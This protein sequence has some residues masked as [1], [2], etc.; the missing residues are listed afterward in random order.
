MIGEYEMIRKVMRMEHP[1][2]R[3]R[4]EQPSPE[5]PME[6]LSAVQYYIIQRKTENAIEK[7][8]AISRCEDTPESKFGLRYTNDWH[9]N[10]GADVNTF[11]NGWYFS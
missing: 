8:V 11:L 1:V 4:T 3:V 9:G 2:I 10:Y 7:D 6:G 5:G